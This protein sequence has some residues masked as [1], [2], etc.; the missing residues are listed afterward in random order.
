LENMDFLCKIVKKLFKRFFS[1]I[2]DSD[3]MAVPNAFKT[4]I[5]IIENDSK[6]TYSLC[7]DM[8]LNH[9]QKIKQG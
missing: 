3:Q 1:L 2:E 7:K 4:V 6:A 5:I 9:A 8:I